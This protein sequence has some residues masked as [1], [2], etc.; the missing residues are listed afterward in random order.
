MLS[1]NQVKNNKSIPNDILDTNL[2]PRV[3]REITTINMYITHINLYFI[4]KIEKN[5]MTETKVNATKT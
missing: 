5:N 3:G 1:Y 2:V 4:W